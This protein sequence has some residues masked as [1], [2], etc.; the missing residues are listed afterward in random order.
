[1]YFG[2]PRGS[3]MSRGGPRCPAEVPRFNVGFRGTSQGGSMG[4][5]VGTHHKNV[6]PCHTAPLTRI[7]YKVYRGFPWAP[8]GD[9]SQRHKKYK[10]LTLPYCFPCS[11]SHSFSGISWS[12]RL[13]S[14]YLDMN[15]AGGQ[16]MFA[17]GK[18]T[19]FHTRYRDLKKATAKCHWKL[20]GTVNLSAYLRLRR[21]ALQGIQVQRRHG[22]GG[23]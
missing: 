10:C 8:P 13:I 18:K 23:V 20:I 22:R 9:P 7:G 6:K 5:P 15:D 3:Q 21:R 14:A 2:V 19:G 1:M 17:T 16:H 4:S 12:S 11:C